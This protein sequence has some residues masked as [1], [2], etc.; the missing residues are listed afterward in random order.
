MLMLNMIFSDDYLGN[1]S[2][3]VSPSWSYRALTSVHSVLGIPRLFS[4]AFIHTFLFH[5]FCRVI[6]N[7]WAYSLMVTGDRGFYFQFYGAQVIKLY[8][9]NC[10]A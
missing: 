6:F 1:L 4:F 9:N 10:H 8:M 7:R 2:L 5:H 3:G